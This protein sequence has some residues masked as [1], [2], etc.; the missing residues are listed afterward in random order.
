MMLGMLTALGAA[1][2]G[3]DPGWWQVRTMVQG[4]SAA[5]MQTVCLAP[6]DDRPR[7]MLPPAIT[8]GCDAQGACRGG[9]SLSIDGSR[10]RD[11]FDVIV[12]RVGPVGGHR[13]AVALLH[14]EGRR[15][16][17]ACART[18]AAASILRTSHA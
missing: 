8:G 12:R 7:A 13:H 18:L 3:I 6:G 16:S 10:T 14:V 11:R 2:S 9:G 17:T 15:L 4:D 5:T 1:L